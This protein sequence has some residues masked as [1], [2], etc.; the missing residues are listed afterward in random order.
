VAHGRILLCLHCGR[1]NRVSEGAVPVARCG[2]CR[3]ALA[4]SRKRARLIPALLV[5]AGVAVVGYLVHSNQLHSSSA[6]P[7]TQQAKVDPSLSGA[8]NSVPGARGVPV[9]TRR[10]APTF[11]EINAAP[12]AIHTGVVW[13]RP[14]S[15][16]IAPFEI[17]TASGK[18]YFLKL[19]DA[20]NGR[21]ELA[22][23]VQGGRTF[24]ADVPLGTYL[25]SYCAGSVWYG[26]AYRFGPETAC[27]QADEQFAF[28]RRG[29]AVTGYTIELILQ[30]N[31]NLR[32]TRID[33]AQF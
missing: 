11:A 20:T 4:A 13:A 22:I 28:Y 26:E 21:E 31:G 5:V 2:H 12:V 23:Y 16:R 3:E 25:L 33:P 6:G 19:S 14:G 8:E 15:V 29:N 10:P 9:P 7:R 30:V 1:Q 32:T 18:D 17:R 24:T 27:F